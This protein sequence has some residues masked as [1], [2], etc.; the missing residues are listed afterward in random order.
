MWPRT[1][2]A[3]GG[4]TSPCRLNRVRHLLDGLYGVS[5]EAVV[6]ESEE[7]EATFE[8]LFDQFSQSRS[9]FGIGFLDSFVGREPL[10]GIAIGAAGFE[11]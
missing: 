5:L 4:R 2:G 11:E 3:A 1:A 10:N 8:T 6:D 7:G 9:A